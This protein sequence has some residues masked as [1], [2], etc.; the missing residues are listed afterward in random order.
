MRLFFFTAALLPTPAL[1]AAILP[2]VAPAASSFAAPAS[3]LVE[4]LSEPFAE[5]IDAPHPRFSWSLAA[6]DPSFRALSQAFYELEVATV[7]GAPP[8]WSSGAVPSPSTSLVAPPGLPAL[9]ASARLYWRVRATAAG[10][11]AVPSAWSAPASFTTGAASWAGSVWVCGPRWDNLFRVSFRLP[12]TVAAAGVASALAHVAGLGWHAVTFNGAPPPGPL[13]GRRKLDGGW[14][15]FAQ[16]VFY[17]TH[18]VTAALVDGENVLGVALGN[19]WFGDAGWYKRPPYGW[20][21]ATNGGGFSYAAPPLLRA[22]LVVRL[23]NGSSFEVAT[24]ADGSGG[25][26]VTTA[27]GPIVFDSLYDGETYDGRRAAALAGWDAP[28][29][30]PTPGDWLP[31]EA[32][33]NSTINPAVGAVLQAQPFEPTLRL[34]SA[35]PIDS[36]EAEP[37]AYVFD[38]GENGIGTVRWT[39]RGLDAGA[40]V[41]MRFAEV[42]LHPPYG[43]ANTSLYFDNLRNAHATDYYIA[44]GSG[45]DVYEATFS[46]HGFR[47]AQVTGVP[48]PPALSDVLVVRQANAATPAAS[49]AFPSR[50]LGKVAAMAVNTISSNL[51][52]GPGSCGQRDERQFFTGDTQVSALTSMQHFRLRPLMYAWVLNALDDQNADGSIGYYLPT[53]IKD[54]RDG[55]PQWST[56]FLTVAWQLMRLEGDVAGCRAVYPAVLRYIAFN[57]EKYTAAVKACGNFSC[58]WDE[59]PSEWQQLGPDPDPHCFNA[60]G[61]IRDLQMAGDVAEGLGEAG[62]AAQ[63]RARAAAR[64]TEFHAVFFRPASAAYGLGTQTE[65]SAGLWLR[66]PPTP[67]VAAAVFASLLATV[68]AAGGKQQAGIVGARFFYDVLAAYGR[69]D[70]GVRILSDDSY[71]SFGFMAAG[72]DNPEPSS[73]LWEIWSAHT[74]DPI[75][76]S[77][78][79][80]MF[81]SYATF[82]LRVACGVEPLG[83]GFS[84][85][86]LV[87]PLG[88]GLLNGTQALLPHAAGAMATPRGAIE[89][90]WSTLAPPAPGVAA[91]GE[92]GEAPAPAWSY[93]HLGCGAAVNATI[94]GVLFADFG[95]PAGACGAGG[96]PFS[97]DPACTSPNGTAAVQSL[98]VGKPNCSV[99]ADIRFWGDPCAGTPKHLAVNVSCS[100]PP[101]AQPLVFLGSLAV[102]MPAGLPAVVRLPTFGRPLAVVVV[103]EGATGTPADPRVFSGGAFV[104]GVEG[105]AAA[106]VTPL[107]GPAGAVA[108]DVSVGSGAYRFTVWATSPAHGGRAR[109]AEVAKRHG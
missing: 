30:S 24:T 76:S 94:S 83:P 97:R 26:V 88:L 28:G 12:A 40:N 38:F 31:V 63:L 35:P 41:T 61:Y 84:R 45:V 101:P 68:E 60:F 2:A 99:P 29:F 66:A 58:Y 93:V 14:T 23:S 39:F 3:L 18:D 21:S 67:E 78:N 15:S 7:A 32:A 22:L 79:H 34:T 1:A 33:N 74:G 9:P 107:D 108:V 46:W 87:W 82:L 11:G 37:G 105:V 95:T 109:R 90:A 51:Q 98:C 75:M 13:G 6:A 55:S 96:V 64:T 47:Y 85:G 10:D 44:T 62:D 49:A 36:W 102:A 86:A 53:P 100:G 8:I 92:G 48:S 104:P 17:T 54:K 73:T 106:A 27:V 77:R 56:G 81:V 16:R 65:L 25:A 70:V 91:C 42:L 80:L 69:A 20:P 103:T 52:G 71:P 50:V 4:S 43:P 57:E 19:G 89:V 59:W 5:G 72:A